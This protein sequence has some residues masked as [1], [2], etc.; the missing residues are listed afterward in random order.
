MM[1]GWMSYSVD[2]GAGLSKEVAGQK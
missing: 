1:I 2:K